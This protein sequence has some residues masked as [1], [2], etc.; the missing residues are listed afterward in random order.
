[1]STAGPDPSAV[2]VGIRPGAYLPEVEALRGIAVLLVFVF[3]ADRFLCLPLTLAGV[4]TRGAV[5][6]PLQAFVR[7]GHTGVSLFFVLSGFLLSL[8]FLAEA[9]G[10]CR[11][12]RRRYAERRS[13]RILPLY[14]FLLLVGALWTDAGFWRVLPYMFFLNGFIVLL[15]GMPPFTDVIWSL[16]TEFQYYVVLP[17]LPLALRTS[18]GRWVGIG[19]LGL[20]GACYLAW[21]AGRFVLPSGGF[22][23]LLL[24]SSIFGRG[25]TFLAGIAAASV[26]QRHGD[27]MRTRAAAIPWLRNGGADVLFA[28]IVLAQGT[29]LL[30]VLH[31]PAGEVFMPPRALWHIPEGVGWALVLLVLLLAPLRTKMLFCN[32]ALIG[33]GVLSYSIFI[34]HVP[35]LFFSQNASWWGEPSGWDASGVVVFLLVSVAVV[36]LSAC[37]YFAIERPFLRRKAW[38]GEQRRAASGRSQG[39]RS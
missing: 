12:D 35:L 1:M 6:S 25:W 17:F 5:T 16:A 20:Y 24:A 9:A 28:A 11:V 19:L 10:G 36:T 21:M 37:T 23:G 3:H 38:L 39:G 13:L 22:E 27:A 8:P 4:D 31:Q 18:R 14:W 26:Y 29:L 7:G 33:L 15:S 32:P 34:W 2:P 30:W